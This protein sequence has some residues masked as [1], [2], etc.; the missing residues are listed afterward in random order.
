MFAC[1]CLVYRVVNKRMC[2][3]LLKRIG[4]LLP[5]IV[6]EEA[7]EPR[8]T[9]PKTSV[10][11]EY[12]TIHRGTTKLEAKSVFDAYVGMGTCMEKSRNFQYSGKLK[13]LEN[14]PRNSAAD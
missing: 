2:A 1:S 6:Q 4:M 13:L 3:L 7:R 10:S 8:A 14:Y 11:E 9:R 5:A 12:A